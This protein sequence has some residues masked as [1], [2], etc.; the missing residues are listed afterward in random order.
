[1]RSPLWQSLGWH[2]GVF[3]LFALV[4]LI[5]QRW[6][7]DHSPNKNKP[8]PVIIK[9][10]APAKEINPI[11]AV[12]V[13]S[14]PK[15]IAPPTVM[16]RKVFGL[17]TKS[18][19]SEDPGAV[20]VK[21]GNTLAVEVDRQ[22]LRPEDDQALPIPAEE[23]LVTQMPRPLNEF[24]I[25]YPPEARAQN[26]EGVVVMDILV[27][28]AGVVREATLLEG[29]GYGLNEAALEAIKRFKFSPALIDQKPVAVRM[30]Y[31]Y[32]FILN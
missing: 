17:Q 25:P 18:L 20:A 27:D 31:G 23:Y 26:I 13:R 4:M 7:R 29:P 11:T 10:V 19:T 21:V 3:M 14:Q 8:L 30:R 9:E 32:R 12:D 1:M 28:E 16:P 5:S 15:P 24:R 2:L 22:Q 6:S